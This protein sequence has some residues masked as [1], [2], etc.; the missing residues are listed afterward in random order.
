MQQISMMSSP[1]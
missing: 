1:R